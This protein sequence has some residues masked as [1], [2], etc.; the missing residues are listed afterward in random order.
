M[1]YG[2]HP[3]FDL[4]KAAEAAQSFHLV[5]V[6]AAV[7]GALYWLWGRGRAER[8][9][10]AIATLEDTRALAML[11]PTDYPVIHRRSVHRLRACVRACPEKNVLEVV[12]GQARLLNPLHV[13]IRPVCPRVR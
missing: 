2:I 1:C 11:F 7:A 13:G 4:L 3:M 9:K 6:S 12:R 10:A 5:I 8:E